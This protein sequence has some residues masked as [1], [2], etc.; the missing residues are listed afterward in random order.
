MILQPDRSIVHMDMDSFFVSV[1]L[2][3]H[4]ELKGKPLIIGSSGDRGVVAS[5][6]YEARKFGIHSAMSSKMARLLC[7]HAIWIR[8]DMEEYSKH[9]QLVR[10]IINEKA[11]LYEQASIDEFYLDITGMDKF[12]GNVKWTNELRQFIIKNS[13]LPIS[14]GLS[15]NKTV[16]KVATNES[17]PNGQLHIPFGTEKSFLAPLPVERMP[18]VGKKT[19]EQLHQVG[20]TDIRT[21]SAMPVRVMESM[22]GKNGIILWQRANAIDHTPIEPYS[23]RKSISTETTFEQDSIDIK[24]FRSRLL[25]MVE[26]L[27]FD[28]RKENF[29][30]GTLTVKLKYSNFDTETKQCSFAYTSSDAALMEKVVE[31]FDKLYN[32]RMLVRLIGVRLSNLVHGSYQIT[33]FDDPKKTINLYAAMDKIRLKYGSDAVGRGLKGK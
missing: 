26:E 31:L 17:K 24:M 23:E 16:A 1:E 2:L 6:S 33:L 15:I 14:Y 19:A 10:Q 30:T 3:R 8:G 7:P 9:S 21:L 22:L 27:C 20:I 18:M 28:L 11:P 32:R 5:C 29:L 12:F 13:G 25:K 4:P